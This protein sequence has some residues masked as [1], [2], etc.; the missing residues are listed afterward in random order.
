[1]EELVELA[2]N[3]EENCREYFPSSIPLTKT[4]TLGN[5]PQGIFQNENNNLNPNR[6]PRRLF[7][8]ITANHA[9]SLGVIEGC[10]EHLCR[11]SSSTQTSTQNQ[12]PLV[13][14]TEQR[15]AASNC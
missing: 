11:A 1:M 5:G 10:G 15:I 13:Q 3:L 9:K 14:L 7:K 12:G 6:S 2:A 4:E 8:N